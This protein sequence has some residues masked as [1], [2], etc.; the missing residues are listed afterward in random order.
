[1]VLG[2]CLLYFNIITPYCMASSSIDIVVSYLIVEPSFVF[3]SAVST[4]LVS[5]T[6]L[7]FSFRPEFAAPSCHLMYIKEVQTFLSKYHTEKYRPHERSRCIFCYL[8]PLNTYILG[9]HLT[10]TGVS[11]VN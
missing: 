2:M 4:C 8:H 11:D 3:C 1:M 5:L 9:H 7:S 6:T 10:C